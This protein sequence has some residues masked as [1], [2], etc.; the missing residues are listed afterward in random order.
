MRPP[1]EQIPLAI[2]AGQ[3]LIIYDD[4]RIYLKHFFEKN[5]FFM[6]HDQYFLG[7]EDEVEFKIFEL[8]LPDVP[9]AKKKT[10]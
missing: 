10:N 3:C 4:T 2:K 8:G 9:F 6:A 7:T 1:K 5:A